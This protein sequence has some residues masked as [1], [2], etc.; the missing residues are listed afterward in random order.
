MD[1]I[2]IEYKSELNLMKEYIKILFYFSI[3][4]FGQSRANKS[5][6]Q[7]YII[8]SKALHK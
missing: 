5:F 4:F 6:T 1:N 8:I 2:L 3:K 7:N